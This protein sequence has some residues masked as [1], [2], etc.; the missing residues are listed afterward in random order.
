MAIEDEAAEIISTL[1]AA[2]D[3]LTEIFSLSTDK[4]HINTVLEKFNRWFIR[5]EKYINEKLGTAEKERFRETMYIHEHAANDLAYL[6]KKHYD[7]SNYFAVLRDELEKH[8]EQ[9]VYERTEN[10]ITESTETTYKIVRNIIDKFDSVVTRLTR[11]HRN[12][13][14]LTMEDEYDVQ[15]LIA[16]LLRLYFRDIREEEPVPSHS[17]SGTI[18]DFLIMDNGAG[19][20]LEIK[21]VRTAQTNR[22]VRIDLNDDKNCYG[23]HPDCK[24]LVHF[25]YDPEAIIQNPTGFENDGTDEE[26]EFPI[27]TFVRP[28]R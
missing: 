5:T 6:Y 11:R 27:S 16:A 18:I 10:S 14:A 25:V 26:G 28:L 9:Y 23:R 4:A 3:E 24:G 17:G 13:S 8:P 20:A 2:K 12:R 15:Y 7:Y 19:L 22:D 21:R 1:S